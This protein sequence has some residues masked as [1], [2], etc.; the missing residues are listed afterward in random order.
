MEDHPHTVG[1]PHR[2]AGGLLAVGG[3][4]PVA[5]VA[6][7][8]VWVGAGNAYLPLGVEDAA[9]ALGVTLA[10]CAPVLW[11]AR[12]VYRGEYGPFAVSIA[13]IYAVPALLAA[14]AM[15]E[16]AGLPVSGT[17]LSAL[18]T[19]VV[20]GA[21][22]L[23]LPAALAMDYAGDPFPPD[24]GRGR[25][26]VW[27]LAWHPW[28]PVV[29]GIVLG[30]AAGA[31]V[32]LVVL[33]GGLLVA[34]LAWF[35]AALYV[36]VGADGV[37]EA[38]DRAVADRRGEYVAEHDPDLAYSLVGERGG[39]PLSGPRWFAVTHALVGADA[40]RFVADCA[41]DVQALSLHESGDL[42]SIEYGRIEGVT[43]DGGRLVVVTVDD[44]T[45]SYRCRER[46]DD[47]VDA[48][49]G[50]RREAGESGATISSSVTGRRPE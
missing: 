15:V 2:A 4:A 47:L 36:H 46:P 37:L 10:A 27:R 45:L 50:R 1:L 42:R 5:F 20:G 28:V 35:G 16:P 17:E 34:F 43:Y 3:G 38:F 8:V 23:S 39:L 44:E 49:D 13:A 6:F 33:L 30:V 41:F 24:L 40:V 19:Y 9:F 7:A 48:I 12:R 22:A 31:A 18:V 29:A 14:S 21:I 11:A 26:L 25:R 32:G